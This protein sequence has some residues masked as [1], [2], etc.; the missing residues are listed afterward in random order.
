MIAWYWLPIGVFIGVLV[1]FGLYH[2]VL[3]TAGFFGRLVQRK[4]EKRI[5]KI[6]LELGIVGKAKEPETGSKYRG[7]GLRKRD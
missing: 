6:G 1:G 5:K 4:V 3:G 7:H 2:W